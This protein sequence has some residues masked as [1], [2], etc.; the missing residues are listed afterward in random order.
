MR[1]DLT[2]EEVEKELDELRTSPFVILARKEQNLRNRRRQYLY[3]LRRFERRGRE[4]AAIGVTLDSI[5]AYIKRI[6]DEIETASECDET[7]IL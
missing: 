7:E 2:D 4:L 1:K 3:A 5:N 6:D